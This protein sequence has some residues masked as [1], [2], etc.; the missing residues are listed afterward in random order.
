MLFIP[1]T[2]NEYPATVTVPIQS[3]ASVSQASKDSQ[4]ISGTILDA[5]LTYQ[6]RFF[7]MLS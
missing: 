5:E 6:H 7:P 3:T 1:T 4:S 2:F